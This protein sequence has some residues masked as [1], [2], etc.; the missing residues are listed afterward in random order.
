MR[1][2]GVLSSEARYVPL[3][4]CNIV[5]VILNPQFFEQCFHA[6]IVLV[7]YSITSCS[8]IE[9]LLSF[10]KQLVKLSVKPVNYIY[11][12]ETQCGMEAY[13]MNQH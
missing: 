12:S 6:R 1:V 8:L 13:I 4:T 2:G 7:A 5:S 9:R 11:Y 3:N 10:T